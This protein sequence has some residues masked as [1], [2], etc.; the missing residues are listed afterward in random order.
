MV[1]PKKDITNYNKGEIEMSE[2]KQ[3]W[4]IDEL[5]TMTETVQTVEIEYAGKVLPIQW[6]ELVESEEPKM[7]IPDESTP[8]EEVNEFYKMMAQERVKA[9]IAKANEM[10]PDGISLNPED[11]D[12]LPTTLR[13]QIS[14][15]IVGGAEAADFTTG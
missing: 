8:S 6:C 4:T 14:G 3:M 7:S 2:E 11:V 10:N 1:N 13:W 5:V 12:K 15:R 9:M